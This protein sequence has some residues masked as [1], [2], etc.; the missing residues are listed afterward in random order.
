[1][2]R[3]PNDKALRG[4]TDGPLSL[5]EIRHRMQAGDE[6]K[7]VQ[8]AAKV[9]DNA[10][11]RKRILLFGAYGNGN[12]GDMIQADSLRRSIMRSFP[13]VGVWATT[14]MA[15]PYPYPEDFK[16]PVGF[17]KYPPGV[18]LF[19]ALL[20]GGGGLLAHPHDPLANESWVGS[21]NLPVLL[22]GIGSTDFFAP[23]AKSLIQKAV[24]ASG[25]DL[26]SLTSLLKFR[27]TVEFAIDPVLGDKELRV[28]PQAG[29]KGTG[30]ILR[31]P[32]T[33]FHDAIKHLVEDD[34]DVI[35]FEPK[36]DGVLKEDFP[37][38]RFVTD[39]AE[40]FSIIARKQRLVSMRYHG[41]ILGLKAGIPSYAY[42]VPKA[43]A[44]LGM[45]GLPACA[46]NKGA[47]LL[48]LPDVDMRRTTEILSWFEDLYEHN[49]KSALRSAL[50]LQ[51]TEA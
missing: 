45:L 6:Y 10:G 1:L 30:W 13:D 2:W 22:F 20:I 8:A 7:I 27:N 51:P 42:N 14:M 25:R 24:H 38:L 43:A 23:Q 11:F 21:L 39:N 49:L 15:S 19:D 47:T 26:E 35:G 36:V 29:G 3:E 33:A 28:A 5:D 31:G 40:F 9:R 37:S 41:V 32:K 48:P 4:W 17:I 12:L 46:S 50:D 16:L 18:A 34:D 44:L